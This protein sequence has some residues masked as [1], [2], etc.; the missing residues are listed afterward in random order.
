MQII[1]KGTECKSSHAF[2]ETKM[3]T[4]SSMTILDNKQKKVL[5][6]IKIVK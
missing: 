2:D 3:E 1:Q 5:I 4:W 6:L